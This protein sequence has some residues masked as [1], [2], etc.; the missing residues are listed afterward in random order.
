MSHV[1]QTSAPSGWFIHIYCC[2]LWQTMNPVRSNQRSSP[3]VH[4]T[5]SQQLSGTQRH[6]FGATDTQP[7]FSESWPSIDCGSSPASAG[8]SSDME[9]PKQSAK[10]GKST[11]LEVRQDSVLAK[12]ALI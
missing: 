8:A 1:Q 3:Q 11:E 7:A 2:V 12:Y 10:A 4:S 9:T 6:C 5:G